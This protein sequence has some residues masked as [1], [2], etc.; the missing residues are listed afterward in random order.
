M[1]TSEEHDNDM[2]MY[3]FLNRVRSLFNI[4]YCLLPELS[5]SDWPRFRDDPPRYFINRADLPQMRAIWREVE[6]RQK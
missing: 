6:K 4:D 1:T 3:G 2:A 5:E